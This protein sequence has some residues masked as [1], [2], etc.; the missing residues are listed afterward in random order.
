MTAGAADLDDVTGAASA[1]PRKFAKLLESVWCRASTRTH[2]ATRRS[3]R[4]KRPARGR[5]CPTGARRLCALSDVDGLTTTAQRP[6]AHD[7]LE[8]R[9]GTSGWGRI[10]REGKQES[11]RR[12]LHTKL[13]A[14]DR[15]GRHASC[16]R[17]GARA[18]RAGGRADRHPFTPDGRRRRA[19]VWLAHATEARAGHPRDGAV[20][21]LTERGHRSARGSRGNGG[22]WTGPG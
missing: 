6:G 8:V 17:H 22:S 21:A 19:A 11:G 2:V 16:S 4:R 1:T 5:S 14:A 9:D 20:R 7:R 12:L 13:E 15:D 3:V 10:G 18:G